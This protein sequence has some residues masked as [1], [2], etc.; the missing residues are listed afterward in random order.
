MRHRRAH[1]ALLLVVAGCRGGAVP[2]SDAA[3]AARSRTDVTVTDISL[4]RS[5]RADRR[6]AEPAA[7][8]A[9]ADTVYASVVTEGTGPDGVLKARW[10]YEGSRVLAEPALT[11][12]PRATTVNEFHISKGDGLPRGAYEVEVFLDGAAVGK[13]RFSVR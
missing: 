4:G 3:A 5:L 9:P 7:A 13:R 10:T 1:L 2:G 12:A 6:I 11:I 8:F